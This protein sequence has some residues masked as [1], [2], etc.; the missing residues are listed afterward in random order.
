MRHLVSMYQYDNIAYEILNVKALKISILYKKHILHFMGKLLYVD[1]Q[2]HPL[3]Y[4]ANTDT[5]GDVYL[6]QK[7]NV[8]SSKLE[9]LVDDFETVPICIEHEND[10]RGH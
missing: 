4:H 5:L 9:E 10:S 7:W 3:K 6:I 2:R 1:F 8:E